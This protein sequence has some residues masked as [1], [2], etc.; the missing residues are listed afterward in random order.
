MMQNEYS[1]AHVTSVHNVLSFPKHLQSNSCQILEL[2]SYKC[3]S[4]TQKDNNT[5]YDDAKVDS[6][7]EIKR[8]SVI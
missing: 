8:T 5:R 7:R 6:E 1:R 2:A 4:L 3:Q